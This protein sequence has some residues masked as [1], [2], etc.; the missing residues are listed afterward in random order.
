MKVIASRSPVRLAVGLLGYIA[1]LPMLLLLSGGYGGILG[2]TVGEALGTDAGRTAE[3]AGYGLLLFGGP[4]LIFATVREAWARVFRQVRLDAD[5]LEFERFGS[6]IS[7]PLDE[8][9]GLRVTSQSTT[10]HYVN[11]TEVAV[12]LTGPDRRRLHL[13][14]LK[15]E[16]AGELTGLAS[17]R[18]ADGMA[19]R[20]EHGPI[21]FGPTLGSHLNIYS[22]GPP[23]LWT[24]ILGAMKLV[25]VGLLLAVLYFVYLFWKTRRSSVTLTASGL[26]GPDGKE[27]PWTEVKSA[28]ANFDAVEIVTTAGS[29]KIHGPENMLPLGALIN[30]KVSA[31]PRGK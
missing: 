7:W 19:R 30:R 21:R 15:A 26:L 18:M 27:T 3:V 10:V 2:F 22:L 12:C 13:T 31:N 8:L 14:D 6:S 5:H 29:W 9:K 28:Q 25:W 20:L 24:P 4:L 17:L 11:V 16:T 1:V 23:L